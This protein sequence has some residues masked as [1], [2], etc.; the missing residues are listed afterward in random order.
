MSRFDW[1]H[2]RLSVAFTANQLI[3]L[4]LE[5]PLLI[6]WDRP[7]DV[8]LRLWRKASLYMHRQGVFH[9]AWTPKQTDSLQATEQQPLTFKSKFVTETWNHKK[10][11]E[12]K[13]NSESAG[14]EIKD[15]SHCE[16]GHDPCQVWMVMM[17]S[18]GVFLV[19]RNKRFTEPVDKEQRTQGALGRYILLQTSRSHHWL[20][21]SILCFCYRCKKQILPIWVTV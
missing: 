10:R 8:Q 16:S 18:T 19:G 6:G 13:V 4:G 7:H 15:C 14:T 5:D 21:Q 11:L 3:P 17:F 12:I 9:A 1:T 2:D 20:A